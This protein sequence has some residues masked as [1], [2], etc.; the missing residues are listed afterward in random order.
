M[1]F[2]ATIVSLFIAALLLAFGIGFKFFSGP[3]VVSLDMPQTSELSYVVIDAEVLELNPGSQ[4]VRAEGA[5]SNTAAYGQSDDVLSW[6]GGSAYSHISL[7]EGEKEPIVEVVDSVVSSHNAP[8]AAAA[9]D[10]SIVSPAGSDMWL[11]ESTGAEAALALKIKSGQSVIVASDGKAPAPSITLEWPLP[12]PEFMWMTDDVLMIAGGIF[13]LLGIAFYLWAL[14]HMRRGHG[15]KRR[16][17]MPKPPKPRASLGR[18]TGARPGVSR[19]RRSISGGRTLVAATIA[20]F[21]VIGVSACSPGSIQQSSPTPTSAESS[22]GPRPVVTEEQ[23]SVILGKAI[24]TVAVADEKKDP[25]VAATRLAGAALEARAANYAMR[26]TNAKIAALPALK[27]SP[28]QLFLPQATST[29]P[30]SILAMVQGGQPAVKDQEPPTVALVLTQLSPR[31][32]YKIVYAINLEAKQRIP[33]VSASSVGTPLV[34]LDTKLLT[35][36]PKDLVSAYADVLAKGT[37]SKFFTQFD[38]NEDTLRA[39]IASERKEQ[40]S[41]KDVAVT[42]ADAMGTGPVAFAAQSAGAIVAVQM[43]EVATFT[44]LNNRDLKLT[45]E[46]KALSGIEISNRVMRATYGMQLFFYVPPVGSNEKIIM[47]GYSENLTMAKA[48]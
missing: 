27:A 17:R 48:Q 22:D 42:F 19:G 3:T 13:L 12:K 41:N 14:M 37:K 28:V 4:L 8:S 39:V 20:G 29:W 9:Q 43:N 5:A 18:S 34:A 16:G 21:M 33:E 45:G 32:N 38:A 47:L 7:P 44:P 23:L 46:I 10:R 25:K 30:R 6:L 2:I 31:S 11:G 24:S 1:R 35:V 26:K 15:P 36:S 40:Q